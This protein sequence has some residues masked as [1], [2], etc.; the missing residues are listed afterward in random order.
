VTA[1]E[2]VKELPKLSAD[3]WAAV[4]R[5][6][7]ELEELDEALFLNEPADALFEEMD[8]EEGKKLCRECS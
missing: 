2:I 6:L 3:E 7:R 1:A 4:R 8:K 5:R